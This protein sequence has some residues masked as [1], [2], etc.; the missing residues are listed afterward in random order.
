MSVRP[1]EPW[2]TNLSTEI[3]S[4]GTFELQLPSKLP[5]QQIWFSLGEYVYSCLYANEEL[6]LTFDLDKLKNNKVYMLGEGMEFAG[7]DGEINQALNAYIMYNKKHLPELYKEFQSLKDED[8]RYMEKLDSLFSLQRKV[9]ANFLKENKQIAKK[10]IESET[11]AYYNSK[12]I[13]YLLFQKNELATIKELQIPIYAI[14]NESASYLKYLYWYVNNKKLSTKEERMNNSIKFAKIDSLF[15]NAYAD[16]IKLQ[17]SSKDLSEQLEINKELGN[18]IKTKWVASY[19]AEENKELTAKINKI[20]E[21]LSAPQDSRNNSNK[22]GRYLKSTSFQANLYLNAAKSGEELLKSIQ[23]AFPGKYIIMDL[24]ATWC[25]PC[26]ANMPRIKELQLQADKEKLPV[27]FVY[28]CTD[29]QSSE[30][31]WQN[32]IA[33]LE[34]PGEHVFVENKQMSDLITLFNGAGYPTYAI[35]KPD[36]EIDTEMIGLNR[37]FKL[38]AL[39]QLIEEQ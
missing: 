6:I 33:E 23:A 16:L 29:G 14:T 9:D 19:L 11:E 37:E 38:N 36:G 12:R 17:V 32:K 28:L 22:I 13:S 34:Q 24:W 21:L 26:L 27:V 20:Q 2:Q 8:A 39:K 31:V 3:A 7:K 30:A 10:I 18:S 5:Y 4:D 1:K 15:P 35:I 25:A